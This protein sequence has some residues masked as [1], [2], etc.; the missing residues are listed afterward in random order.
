[1]L[2]KWRFASPIAVKISIMG[3]PV[4]L[5]PKL[6]CKSGRPAC[7]VIGIPRGHQRHCSR[8]NIPTFAARYST[9][10]PLPAS[11]RRRGQGRCRAYLQPDRL[12]SPQAGKQAHSISHWH[13]LR[14]CAAPAGPVLSVRRV[15]V[16]QSLKIFASESGWAGAVRG[17]RPGE[18]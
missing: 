6:Y 13:C 18:L 15:M 2:A 9:S 5:L 4:L 12:C 8:K 17:G 7:S 3:Q 16:G 11:C 14:Q 1:M 10:Y